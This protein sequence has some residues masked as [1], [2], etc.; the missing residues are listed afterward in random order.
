MKA[1]LIGDCGVGK[2]AIINR[3]T[4]DEFKQ[5]TSATA[6]GSYQPVMAESSNGQA[7]MLQL[8]DTPGS[9]SYRSLVPLYL[10][11]S[12]V[13]IL[14]YD[15]TQRDSFSYLSEW[16]TFCRNHG[17]AHARLILVGNKTDLQSYRTVGYNEGESFAGAIGA[18]HFVETSAKLKD[19]IGILLQRVADEVL[20]A[21]AAET[22]IERTDA[23]VLLEKPNTS[24]RDCCRT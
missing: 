3:M 8:W 7:V 5:S 18:K 10:R 15:L 17:P 2:T 9:E 23:A 11:D 12:V 22:G 13:I 24:K 1:A 4:V 19:G 16:V 20:F 14:V 6:G 21:A